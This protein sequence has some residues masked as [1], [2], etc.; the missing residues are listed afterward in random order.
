MPYLDS[1][2]ARGTHLKHMTRHMLGLFQGQPGARAWRRHLSENAHRPGAGL[3]VV[4]VALEKM[5]AVAWTA[6]ESGTE[7]Q[8]GDASSPAAGRREYI[9][10]GL[11]AASMRPTPVGGNGAGTSFQIA[12]FFYRK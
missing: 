10:V 9:P 4:E 6:I 5:A 3:R 2:L 11:T 12:Q 8:E 1:Q 7:A